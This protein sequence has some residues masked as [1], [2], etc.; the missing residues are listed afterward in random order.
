MF[1][2]SLIPNLKQLSLS[3]YVLRGITGEPIAWGWDAMKELGIK[4]IDKPDFGDAVTFR[5]GE[6]P[7][8]WVSMSTRVVVLILEVAK[9]GRLAES[10]L[11]LPSRKQVQR[12][13]VR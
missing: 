2:C 8:F 4:D 3:R 6:I 12:L 5:E 7:V 1:N 9:S 13:R 10:R 11:R